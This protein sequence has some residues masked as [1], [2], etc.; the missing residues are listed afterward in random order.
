MDIDPKSSR[1]F[2]QV[3][4]EGTIRAV[5]EQEHIA[6]AAVS[7]R[8]SDLEATLGV[9]LVKRSNRG[10]QPTDAGQMLIS[11][12]HRVLN[13]LEGLSMQMHDYR[14]GARGYVRIHANMS[15]INQFLPGELSTWLSTNPAVRIDLTQGLSSEIA[16]AV[17]DNATDI[18]LLVVDERLEGV[19]YLPYRTDT[20]VIVCA[21]SHPLASR[22]RVTFEQTLPYMYIGLTQGSQLNLQLTRAAMAA[23]HHWQIR[24][25]VHNYGAQTL[26]V[27]AGL[28][29]GLLP[30]RIA[31]AH[32]KALDIRIIELDEAWAH[33]QIHVCI[34]SYDSLSVTARGL[35]DQMVGEGVGKG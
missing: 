11:R 34:R 20:L 6:A 31:E 13:E 30:R 26:M 17:V 1:L 9:S 21:P 5:A 35:V 27:E 19:D 10:L 23:G 29:L 2:V 25:L 14:S 18:G 7:R 4:Q 24:F 28:G 32:A 33:R 3:M 15:A 22:S 16:Q 12:S 8:I